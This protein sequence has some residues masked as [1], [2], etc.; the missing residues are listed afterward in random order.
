MYSEY[1]GCDGYGSWRTL[2]ESSDLSQ[3]YFMMQFV[4][5]LRLARAVT[6]AFD[7]SLAQNYSSL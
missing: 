5:Y 7:K 1:F 3:S 2:K 4:A 6:I